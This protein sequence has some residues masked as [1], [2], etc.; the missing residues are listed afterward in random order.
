M[1]APTVGRYVGS[2]VTRVEDDRLLVGKGRYIAD[3]DR[4]GLLHAAFLRSPVPHARIL[5]I[6]V[7]AA[8]RLPGVVAVITGA[9]MKRMTNPFLNLGM[10][11]G[12]Y[13]PLYWALAVDRVRM[14][15]DPVAIV[16]AESRYVAEDALE[17]IDVDVRAAR[18]DRHPSRPRSTRPSRRCGTGPTATC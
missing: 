12:L 5:G 13:S 18:G 15:G 1:R 11:D 17:L 14:V 7:A 3:L 10:L 6:D 8:R 16:V 9:E 2:S 4:P